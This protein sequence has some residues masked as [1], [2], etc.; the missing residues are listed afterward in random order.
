MIVAVHQPNYL[1]WLGFFDKMRSCDVFVFLD[2]AAFS[3]NTVE[4]SNRIK[5]PN[6][7][8][9]LTVPVKTAGKFG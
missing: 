8:L 3:K 6:G 2:D 4:N 5:T 1:P 9:W 7:E